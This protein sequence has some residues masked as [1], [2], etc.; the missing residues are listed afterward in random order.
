MFKS[1]VPLANSEIFLRIAQ[2]RPKKIVTSGDFSTPHVG[3]IPHNCNMCMKEECGL[4]GCYAVWLR[5]FGGT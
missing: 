2:R 1:L 5:R 3:I 4:L